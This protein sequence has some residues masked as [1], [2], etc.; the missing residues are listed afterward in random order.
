M[1]LSR[2]FLLWASDNSWIE[3]RFRGSWFA[4]RAVS[5]FMPGETA[6]AA[7]SVAQNLSRAEISSVVTLLGE[8]VTELEEAEQVT[9]Q[10]IAV[11]DHIHRTRIPVQISVKPTQLALELDV[12]STHGHL[13]CLLE[14]AGARGNFVW[15]DMESS[16]DAEATI[17]LFERLREKHDNVGLCLQSYLRRTRDDLER[18]LPLRPAIRL[19]KGAY[20]EPPSVAFPKK[21]DVDDNY[22]TLAYRMVDAAADA[23][24]CAPAFGTHD[25]RLVKSIL[26]AAS[27]RGLPRQAFEIQMLYG[28]EREQQRA[29]ARDGYAVRVLISYGTAWFPWYVRRLAERPAN[30]WFVVRSAFTR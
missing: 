9:R 4:S 17:R 12:E 6:E 10:Y 2:R 1:G 26:H 21:R 5:R 8:D 11:L 23:R 19:V 28:I 30:V 3:R 24:S 27:E 14:H 13:T 25:M 20:R 15:M 22:L 29:L 16:R 18:L 7:L